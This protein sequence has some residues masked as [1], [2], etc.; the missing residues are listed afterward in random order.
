MFTVAQRDATQR[1]LLDLAA[2]DPAIVGAAVTGSLAT[3]G[4]DR[5]SDIDLFFG[6]DGP[7]EATLERVTAL[8]YSQLAALHHWDLPAGEAVYRVFLLPDALEVDLGFA[9]AAAFAPHGPQW[10]LVFGTAAAARPVAPPSRRELVG[11]AWHHA[12]HARVAIARDQYW[13]AEHWIGALREKVLA[14]AALRLGRPARDLPAEVTAPLAATLVRT[15]DAVELRRALDVLVL[16][17]LDEVRRTDP[18]LAARLTLL[19]G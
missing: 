19:R 14:L 2:A 11:L 3:G 12:L 4:G 18:D 7:L 5:F 17:G 10:R 9:A 16:V 15:L 8:V 6:V 1:H 13:A